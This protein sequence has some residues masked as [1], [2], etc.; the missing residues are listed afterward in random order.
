V[1]GWNGYIK[2]TVL[3]AFAKLPKAIISFV[4]PCPSA[5]RPFTW[6]SSAPSARISIT[7]DIGVYFEILLRKFKFR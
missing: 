2:N 6:N 7:F 1:W 3:G 5:A 4:I